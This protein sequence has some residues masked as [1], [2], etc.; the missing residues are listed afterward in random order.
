MSIVLYGDH[1][2]NVQ[3]KRVQEVDP[4]VFAALLV[5]EAYAGDV[6]VA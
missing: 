3:V 4:L 6:Y 2:H 1:C 5:P